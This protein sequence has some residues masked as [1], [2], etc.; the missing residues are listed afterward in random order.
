MTYSEIRKILEDSGIG[1]AAYEAQLLTEQF[2]GI[3]PHEI[4]WRQNENL[5]SPALTEAVTRRAR[6]EPLQYILGKWTFFGLDFFLN[7]DCLIPRAD[8]ELTVELAV[9][10]LP[11][12][13]V[14]LDIG[15][16]SGAISVA[17]LHERD[18]VKAVGL[19]IS[20]NALSAARRNADINGVGD[21]FSVLH[22][23]ALSPDTYSALQRFDAVISNPPYIPSAIIPTLDPELSFEPL[24]ALDGGDDGLDFYRVITEAADRILL[25]D[26]F[27]LYE[28]GIDEETAI[29]KF[30]AEKGFGCDE[31]R[32]I[33]G[34]VRSLLLRHK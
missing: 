2:C 9:A 7:E 14:F 20:D 28:I 11:R 22:A 33:S 5:D 8:T 3:P 21:R 4:L 25:P 34:T 15:T 16:G 12:G 31:Y 18:D 24:R 1:S 26:G 17:V 23:D 6:R 27:L 30:A 29:R 13:A 19:D 10:N 32:D